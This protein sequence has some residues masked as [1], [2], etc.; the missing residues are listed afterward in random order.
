MR[1]KLA[2]VEGALIAQIDPRDVKISSTKPWPT[3]SLPAAS[4]TKRSATSHG[5]LLF[6]VHVI[7]VSDTTARGRRPRLLSRT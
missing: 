5:S 2:R 6:V 7:T 1:S 4:L 3:M